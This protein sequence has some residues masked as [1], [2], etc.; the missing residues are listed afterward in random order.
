MELNLQ[1]IQDQLFYTSI[2]GKTYIIINESI[3]IHLE[4]EQKHL[5]INS[6][7]LTI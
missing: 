3:E 4:R 5:Y 1:N 2:N 7:A 6:G